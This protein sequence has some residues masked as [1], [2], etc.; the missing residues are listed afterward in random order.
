M[1]EEC[2]SIPI[3]APNDWNQNGCAAAQELV[4]AVMMH[5]RLVITAPSASCA[6]QPWRHAAAM[7]RQIGAAGT[8]A[9]ILAELERL[10]RQRGDARDQKRD[11]SVGKQSQDF[12]G[13]PAGVAELKAVATL[14]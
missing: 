11:V 3:T 7:E 4:A 5:D 8:R 13:V 1:P 14:F 6:R 10:Q 9:L 12:R 2:Q